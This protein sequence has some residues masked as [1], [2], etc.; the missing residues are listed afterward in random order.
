MRKLVF[1]V[2]LVGM[3][4]ATWAVASRTARF[5]VKKWDATFE[6]VVRH[7]LS[8]FGFTDHDLVSSVHEVRN[9]RKGDWITHR[10]TVA[11]LPAD[12]K[13][14]LEEHLRRAGA[15]VEILNRGG[16][17]VLVVRRGGRTYHEITFSAPRSR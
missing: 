10:L 11:T 5:S 1:S 8:S 17:E 4:A 6:N 3:G 9:D 2:L 15:E 16:K 12:K 13:A 14:A 7:D